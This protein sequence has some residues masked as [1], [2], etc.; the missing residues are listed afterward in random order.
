[1]T[2]KPH[3]FNYRSLHYIIKTSPTKA[4]YLSEI[5]VR[6]IFEEGWSEIDHSIRYPY[7][8]DN[9]MYNEYLSILNRFAGGADE[10]G[11][12]IKNLGI[13]LDK[14]KDIAN[15]QQRLQHKKLKEL[16]SKI[17]STTIAKEQKRE[18]IIEIEKLLPPESTSLKSMFEKLLSIIN[19]PLLIPEKPGGNKVNNSNEVS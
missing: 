6:T 2:A 19:A 9:K 5:Q 4:T 13:Y 12:F 15:E 3:P 18:I 8:V 11:T 17:N 14:Q 10:M 7:H 1:M 16:I